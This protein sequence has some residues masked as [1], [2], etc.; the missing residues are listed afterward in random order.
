MDLTK[1]ITDKIEELGSS[2]AAQEYF[3]VS[4]TAISTWRSGKI[5]PTLKA[6]QKVL[7]EMPERAVPA[8]MQIVEQVPPAEPESTVGKE[9]VVLLMPIYET[10]EPLTF[11]TL[12]RSMKLYGME[13]V[14][15]IPICRTLIDEARNTLVQK[16]MAIPS[17]PEWCIFPDADQIFPCGHGG[18]L[19]KMGLELPEPKASRNFLTRLMS[20]PK[21][22]R[23]VGAL[24]KNRRGSFKPAVEIAYRSPQEDAR[25]RGLFDGSTKTDG[26]EETGW[27]GFGGVR[28]HR[29]VFEEFQAAAAPGGLLSEIAPPVGRERDA[30]GYFGR[31]PQWRGED[32]SFCRRAQKIGI[33]AYVD[34]G[35]LLGHQGKQ[36]NLT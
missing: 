27:V 24:Y 5:S 29:S 36:F 19:K 20:H 33:K 14:S 9:E 28:I 16:F 30:F 4:P 23:I 25:I 6:A 12:V 21:E 11:I 31:T 34:T 18:I 2:A 26:L 8:V 22:A 10:V 15:I 1:I 35:C 13:K 3:G 17:K 7:D 32:I